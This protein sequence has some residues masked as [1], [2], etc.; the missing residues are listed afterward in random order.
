[1][2]VGQTDAAEVVQQSVARD[3]GL[4]A[5]VL[6]AADAEVAARIQL[7]AGKRNASP[8]VVPP[9]GVRIARA[10]QDFKRLRRRVRFGGNC[11]L[12]RDDLAAAAW[13][14]E[15]DRVVHV[16]Q[17]QMRQQRHREAPSGPIRNGPAAHGE[18]G[19]DVVV[20]VER[21][22]DL[23][24]VVLALHAAGRLARLL[25]GG[26]QQSNQQ[27]DD[28]HHDQQFNQGEAAI[29]LPTSHRRT[30][31]GPLTHGLAFRPAVN[32]SILIDRARRVNVKVLRAAN[33]ASQ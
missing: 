7:S 13:G 30:A 5:G 28:G 3:L 19:V 1:M 2:H 11:P 29:P 18:R 6:V 22:T 21:Q 8:A 23:L 27:G 25:H 20:V 17:I 10:K 32:D 26:K 24:Q 12:Q 14:V 33:A 4:A 31:R 9:L 16:G 15:V